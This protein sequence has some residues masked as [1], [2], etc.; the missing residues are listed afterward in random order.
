MTNPREQL[1]DTDEIL[2]REGVSRE[3]MGSCEWV[4]THRGVWWNMY[5]YVGET[6]GFLIGKDV[7]GE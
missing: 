3:A 2:R 5:R 1:T 6:V 4:S 7:E